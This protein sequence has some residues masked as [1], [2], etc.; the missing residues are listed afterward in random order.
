MCASCNSG[1]GDDSIPTHRTLLIL[2]LCPAVARSGCVTGGPECHDD[3]TTHPKLS[4]KQPRTAS[5]C[6]G[7]NSAGQA[8]YFRSSGSTGWTATD[9]RKRAESAWEADVLPLNYI[10]EPG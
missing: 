9:P 7:L 5:D 10:G 6:N 1:L 2:S 3:V 4:A 8:R